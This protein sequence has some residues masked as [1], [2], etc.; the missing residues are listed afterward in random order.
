MGR[1]LLPLMTCLEIRNLVRSS[2]NGEE[3]FESLSVVI[4]LLRSSMNGE[5]YSAFC[6]VMRNLLRSSVDKGST[7]KESFAS[8]LG[9]FSV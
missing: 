8:L 1:N 9:I 5:E 4:N 3:S 7:R 6:L 2:M